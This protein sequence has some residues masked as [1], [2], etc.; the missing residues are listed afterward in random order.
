M[1]SNKQ[2]KEWLNKIVSEL[3][4]PIEYDHIVHVLRESD[5]PDGTKRVCAL[6]LIA[7]VVDPEG[8]EIENTDP[9][10]YLGLDTEECFNDYLRYS[11]RGLTDSL[12]N[13]HFKELL[14]IDFGYIPIPHRVDDCGKD[15]LCIP[16]GIEHGYDSCSEQCTGYLNYKQEQMDAYLNS[17]DDDEDEYYS[18]EGYECTCIE[19]FD[20]TCDCEDCDLTTLSDDMGYEGWTL[21]G[22]ALEDLARDQFNSL[23]A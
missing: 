1:V 6:G 20:C 3:Y 13:R 22:G 18:D 8:W 4:N 2:R 11:H 16:C 19:E 17:E 7:D 9:W 12:D 5:F 21:I 23:R 10:A 15:S 14:G